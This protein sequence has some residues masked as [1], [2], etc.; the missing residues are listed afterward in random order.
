MPVRPYLFHLIRIKLK[1]ILIAKK[2]H[3]RISRRN[4]DLAY[5]CPFSQNETLFLY[6]KTRQIFFH[7]IRFELK[8]KF[9]HSLFI[10]WLVTY[11]YN[12]QAIDPHALSVGNMYTTNHSRWFILVLETTISPPPFHKAGFLLDDYLNL[13]QRTTPPLTGIKESPFRPKPQFLR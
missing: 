10:P 7:L 4:Y 3:Y 13:S 11:P 12:I 2:H 6:K 9:P 8:C 1:S 5:M